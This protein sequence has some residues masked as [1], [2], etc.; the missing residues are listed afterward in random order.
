[1]RLSAPISEVF[2]SLQ[3]EG[4]SAGMPAIFVRLSGCNLSCPFCDTNHSPVL[5]AMTPDELIERYFEKSSSD[6][7]IVI[8]GGEP[9]LHREWL[10]KMVIKL[11]GRFPV[12]IETNG[13]IS[14]VIFR[15]SPFDT[16]GVFYNI[17]PKKKLVWGDWSVI[18]IRSVKI[19]FPY[20]KDCEAEKVSGSL[21]TAEWY[22]IQPI[23]EKSGQV[24]GEILMSAMEEVARLGFPWHL[25]I[26]SH[27][28][29]GLK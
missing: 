7:L 2:E 12:E 27:K 21:P 20:L 25:S 5:G 4:A 3:G 13:S 15:N 19:L 6:K 17:S 14:P 29:L 28:L 18:P 10:E 9:L 11:R 24:R 1:M 22:G 23:A 8:T 26:Q 16:V